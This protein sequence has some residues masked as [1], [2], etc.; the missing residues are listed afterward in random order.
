MDCLRYQKYKTK[1]LNNRT[2]ELE[3]DYNL[4]KISMND[5]G[6]FEK[7]KKKK[8]TKNIENI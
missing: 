5:M 3:N 1:Q 8:R 7:K 4:I 6:K 2:L